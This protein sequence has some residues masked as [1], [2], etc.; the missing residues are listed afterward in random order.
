MSLGRIVTM[1]EN[2]L[3]LYAQD[4]K[5]SSA[6]FLSTTTSTNEMTTYYWWDNK[7]KSLFIHQR[8]KG[9]GRDVSS[10]SDFSDFSKEK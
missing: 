9:N 3:K 6:T 8:V 1:P 5:V 10:F 2:E 4:A 7:E